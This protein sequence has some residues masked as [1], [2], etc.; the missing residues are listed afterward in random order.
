MIQSEFFFILFILNFL[1]T[2]INRESMFGQWILQTIP[3]AL[4]P[5]DDA[6]FERIDEEKKKE[7]KQWQLI[8]IK[9][10]FLHFC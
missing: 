1:Q 4:W 9:F 2:A 7:E 5:F 3:I 8:F 10:H 6:I